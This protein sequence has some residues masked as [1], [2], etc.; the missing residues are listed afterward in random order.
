MKAIK[1]IKE[2]DEIFNDYGQIP[3]SDLVR[4]YGYVTDNYA[5]YDVV[6]LSLDTICQAA[7]LENADPE[8]Q[9]PVIFSFS[10]S[11]PHVFVFSILTFITAQIP[12]RSR[13]PR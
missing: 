12:G 11:T 2:G 10:C 1:P 8:T 9:Q 7:G 13:T 5:P 3:R 4:R 6:E